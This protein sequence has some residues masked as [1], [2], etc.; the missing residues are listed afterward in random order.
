MNPS[1]P[2]PPELTPPVRCVSVDVEEYYHVEAAHKTL[3]KNDWQQWPSRVSESVDTLLELFDDLGV[4]AT[5]FT[6]GHVAKRTPEVVRAIAKA[7][8]EV[9]SHGFF[10][11]RLHRLNPGSFRVDLLDSKRL[12]EDLC[13]QAVVGY[14]APT[15][16]VVPH[17]AWAIDVLADAGFEY[18]SSIF[19]VRHPSYGVP[20]GPDRPYWVRGPA[21]G[22]MLEIPPLTLRL[23]GR[24]FPVAGGGYFRLLPLTLMKLGLFQSARHQRPAVLYF[25][26]W[27]FD[28]DFPKLPLS[29]AGRLRTY[30]G[31]RQAL[32]KLRSIVAAQ[33]SWQPM[34]DVQ[35]LLKQQADARP[36]F[37]LAKARAIV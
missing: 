15:F 13:G 3:S 28:P 21:G 7:G 9:A 32:G 34:R 22:R 1:D 11:D 26:P 17:T 36:G 33:T 12:L 23:L 4:R 25:H 18:D 14:R 20:S 31:R 35:S 6:L 29:F 19:P 30:T 2:M 27:E 10:H 37:D 24:N 5:F 16:S 8:H